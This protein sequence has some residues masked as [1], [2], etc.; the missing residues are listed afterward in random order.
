[1]ESTPSQARG[2]ANQGPA[3]GSNLRSVAYI[4][5]FVHSPSPARE[6]RVSATIAS[7][8]KIGAEVYRM[9]SG[10]FVASGWRR[11]EGLRGLLSRATRLVA[12]GTGVGPFL[13]SLPVRPDLVIV[14]G[15][16][17]RF[18][19]PALRW[20]DST[21][22]P[23]VN[24]VLDLYEFR[25][26]ETVGTKLFNLL[27]DWW[28]F[29][30]LSVRS[31]GAVV[32]TR[33]LAHRYERREVPFLLLPALIAGTDGVPDQRTAVDG[34]HVGYASTPLRSDSATIRNVIEIANRGLVPEGVTIHMVGTIPRS[35]GKAVV[36]PTDRGVVWH[37]LVPRDETLA[38]LSGCT[39][40]ILQRPPTERWA[41]AGF[42]SK[43]AESLLLGKPLIANLFGDMSLYLRDQEN[44]V[45]LN[46]DGPD[47]LVLGLKGAQLWAADGAG[48][49]VNAIAAQAREWFGPERQG[50]ELVE[51]LASIV[52]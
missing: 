7:L 37:G 4:D 27:T 50:A 29:R 46:D 10:S 39:F 15:T 48:P 47:A 17:P 32:A 45:V 20:C 33:W 14:L 24:E 16:D 18:L 28:G 51:F 3:G 42:P 25:D 13:A 30:G 52:K 41:L 40:T 12:W 19:R 11:L 21:G 34:V 35:L 5:P 8:E 1:M 2:P 23:L 6:Q 22:I 36:L 38:I 43:V 49:N 31:A 26:G 9:P 44:A